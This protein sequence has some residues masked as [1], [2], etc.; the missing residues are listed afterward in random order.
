MKTVTGY[1]AIG[2][3][4]SQITVMADESDAIKLAN[5]QANKRN[6]SAPRFYFRLV[7][8]GPKIWKVRTVSTKYSVKHY[9]LDAEKYCFRSGESFETFAKCKAACVK[10]IRAELDCAKRNLRDHERSLKLALAL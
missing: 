7:L 8:G 10:R 9:T 5:A 3:K 6:P 1:R 2:G 4:V